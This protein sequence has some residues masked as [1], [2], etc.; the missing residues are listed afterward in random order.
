[1][2]LFTD[3]IGRLVRVDGMKRK[4]EFDSKGEFLK[5]WL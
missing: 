2:E 1:M 3:L 5:A 4:T